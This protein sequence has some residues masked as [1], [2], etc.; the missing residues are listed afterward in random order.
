MKKILLALFV[1]VA[2]SLTAKAEQASN[3]VT[4]LRSSATCNGANINNAAATAL[5]VDTKTAHTFVFIYN[6]DGAA[7]IYCSEK[8]NVTTSGGLRGFRI[9]PGAGINFTLPLFIN[10]YCRSGGGAPTPA[11]ICTGS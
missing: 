9:G 6:E 8:S 7:T 11:M 5:F 10:W 4:V 3:V 2:L 1:M